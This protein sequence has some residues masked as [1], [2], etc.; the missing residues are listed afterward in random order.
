MIINNYNGS[1]QENN[2][3]NLTSTKCPMVNIRAFDPN[4]KAGNSLVIPYYV[5][6]FDQNEYRDEKLGPTF[7]TI[8]ALD[9]DTLPANQV[10]V[11][12]QTTYAGEQVI[13][14]G[15]FPASAE[16]IHTLN[17]RTIQSNGVGSATIPLKFAVHPATKPVLDF[18]TQSGFYGKFTGY[19][20]YNNIWRHSSPRVIGPIEEEYNCR[21]VVTKTVSNV[22][23]RNKVTDIKIVVIK[24]K[25][26]YC[27]TNHNIDDYADRTTIDG[28]YDFVGA[29]LAS[30]ESVDGGYNSSTEEVVGV[31]HVAT[32][33]VVNGATV[34][35][36]DYL[37]VPMNQLPSEVV[38]TAAMNK[39]ALTRLFEAAKA[40]RFQQVYESLISGGSAAQDAAI[41]ASDPIKYEFEFKMPQMDIVCDYHYA[42]GT[43][44]YDYLGTMTAA[45]LNDGVPDEDGEGGTSG[46]TLIAAML[47]KYF[48]GRND[49]MVPD[50]ITINLNGSVL[51]M[52]QIK[53]VHGGRLLHILN[54]TNSQV[55]NGSFVGIYKGVEF[56]YPE[57]QESLHLLSIH[58]SLFCSFDDIDVSWSSGY[59]LHVGTAIGQQIGDDG[60]HIPFVSRGYIDYSNNSHSVSGTG[61]GWYNT[62]SNSSKILNYGW[63]V[64]GREFRITKYHAGMKSFQH[65]PSCRAM[66]IHFYDMQDNFI[67][68]VK[69]SQRWPVL[70]PYGA[71]K[72]KMT[73]YG[74]ADTGGDDSL[75]YNS[76]EGE[77]ARDFCNLSWCCGVSGVKIHDT[78]TCALDNGGVQTYVKGVRFQNVAAERY[79]KGTRYE[80]DNYYYTKM[81]V[82]YEDDSFNLYSSSFDD[83]EMLFGDSRCI[84]IVRGYDLHF[85]NCRNVHLEIWSETA[86]MLIENSVISMNMYHGSRD[87]GSGLHI[88]TRNCIIKAISNPN[89][90]NN[91]RTHVRSNSLLTRPK[92]DSSHNEDGVDYKVNVYPSIK[93]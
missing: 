78:R 56:A 90:E 33:C 7:T 63:T 91:G 31:F 13:D 47:N 11:W 39:V 5:S 23:G 74:T 25:N 34:N 85:K 52:L 81:L 68:T 58:A 82:D 89:Y 20:R 2:E 40:W 15:A 9:E 79:G 16:G 66:Y 80:G 57:D 60:T 18:S 6:D 45:Q 17:V 41:E 64:C 24:P 36:A 43:S 59:E 65:T 3:T 72:M 54:N 83:V 38:S 28:Q 35:L 32:Q 55:K 8:F 53:N 1:L 42:L 61:A 29:P 51:S 37:G 76:N 21:Y 48:H 67:K 71:W 50:G 19:R 44:C 27:L 14:L 4:L 12:K 75:N 46:Q 86:D 70:I 49:I 69:V 30:G 73:M 22:G 62:G 87:R 26:T 10:T 88:I 77:F 93:I 92:G 84:N